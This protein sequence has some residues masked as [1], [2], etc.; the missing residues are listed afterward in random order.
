MNLSKCFQGVKPEDLF[1]TSMVFIY[2]DSCNKMGE[3][4]VRGPTCQ[5]G[6]Q[7]SVDSGSVS[8]P[9]HIRLIQT[10]GLARQILG[11]K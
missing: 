8:D 6:N 5:D 3:L 9:C 10:L 7:G 11:D 2:F 4:L 1:S